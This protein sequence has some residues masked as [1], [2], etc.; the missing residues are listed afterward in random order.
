MGY[1]DNWGERSEAHMDDYICDFYYRTY[2]FFLR[3]ALCS[4]LAQARCSLCLVG[5]VVV[6]VAYLS[7]QV[8]LLPTALSLGDSNCFHEYADSILIFA[9]SNVN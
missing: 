5:V 3:R 4:L 2:F 9:N 7:V 8:K 1:S 6:S